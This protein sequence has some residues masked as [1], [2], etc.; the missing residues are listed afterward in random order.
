MV[1]SVPASTRR[2]QVFR[3]GVS[4]VRLDVL[5]LDDGRPVPALQSADFE[6]FDN[7]ARQEITAAWAER[8]PLDVVF[9]LDHSESVQGETLLRRRCASA[10][11]AAAPKSSSG[12]AT[13]CASAG[14]A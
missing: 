4:A 8:T 6:V 10:S 11:S 7:G 9:A 14:A 2:A 1:A 12:P 5:V 13:S 3:S